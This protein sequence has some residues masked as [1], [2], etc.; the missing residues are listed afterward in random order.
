MYPCQLVCNDTNRNEKIYFRINNTIYNASI[1]PGNYSLTTLSSALVDAMNLKFAGSVSTNPFSSQVEILTNSFK[2]S[3]NLAVNFEILTDA[4]LTALGINKPFYSI[5]SIIK[6]Y[7]ATINNN[8]NP[9]KSGF[10]DLMPMRNIY[11]TSSGLGNFETMSMSGERLIIEKFQYL[12][13]ME[14]LFL[15]RLSKAWMF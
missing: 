12:Q 3:I 6:N 9:F 15:I 8:S 11:M 1:A 5:N 14:R 7:T 10:I 2:I 13:V 4:Q